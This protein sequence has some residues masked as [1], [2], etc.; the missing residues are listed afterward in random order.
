MLRKFLQHLGPWCPVAPVAAVQPRPSPVLQVDDYLESEC[1][2]FSYSALS[3]Q[4][5][6]E[7]G[8]LGILGKGY[9]KGEDILLLL[10]RNL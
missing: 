4:P 9:P 6:Q 8:G 3:G 10:C 7:E 5:L 1:S 2:L